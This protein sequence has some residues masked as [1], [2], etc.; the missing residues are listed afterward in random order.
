MPINYL[1]IKQKAWE[2]NIAGFDLN[3]NS[4]R[5]KIE[6][7]AI[8]R[9]IEVTEL[10]AD[11]VNSKF[12]KYTFAK[13]PNRQNIYEKAAFEFLCNIP[14]IKDVRKLAPGGE[15]AYFVVNGQLT[16][17]EKTSRTH[18]EQ[19][20]SKSIDFKFIVKPYNQRKIEL[21]CYA[22]HK[23]TESE[24]G[25]QDNQYSDLRLFLENC[26]TK[27]QECYIVFADGKYYTD[28]LKE[29]KKEFD[30]STKRKVF[31]LNEFEV[32]VMEGEII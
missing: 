20:K 4:V 18:R 8:L 6:T 27:R 17:G 19:H 30:I 11:I 9:G 23:Y 2:E 7:W 12:F 22:M 10:M 14:L 31:T 29:L 1:A 21:T 26:P 24:G 28:R 15:K 3:D 25:A 32:C 16:P 5:E 13:D